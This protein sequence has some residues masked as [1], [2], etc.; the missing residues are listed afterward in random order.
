MRLKFLLVTWLLTTS[1]AVAQGTPAP[2]LFFSDLI[3]GANTG[4]SDKTYS[5]TGGVYVTL[6]GNYLDSYS[7]ITLNGSSCLTVV[8]A[9]AAYL[10]Y[11]KMVVKIGSG[12]NTGNFSITTP[13][14][15]WSGPM[16]ST[17]KEQRAADFTVSSGHIYYVSSSGKDSGTGS[18]S[19][20]W[21]SLPHAKLQMHAG[22]VTYAEN[23]YTDSSPDPDIGWGVITLYKKVCAGSQTLQ[24]VMA[25]YPGATVTL[26]ST[27]GV[28]AVAMYAS[29]SGPACW[30]YTFAGIHFLGHGTALSLGSS[31]TASVDNIRIIGNDI[32]CPNANAAA[33]CE[34]D[35][36]TSPTYEGVGLIMEGNNFHDIG[37]IPPNNNNLQHAIYH[38]GTI[39]IIDAWNKIYNVNGACRGIQI[40]SSNAR[41]VFYDIH[42]HDNIIHD[43][44]CDGIGYYGGDSTSTAGELY[45]GGSEIYNNVIYRTGTTGTGRADSAGIYISFASP[46]STSSIT[47]VYNNTIYDNRITGG[48]TC[49][50][51]EY[52]PEVD[53]QNNIIYQLVSSAPYLNGEGCNNGSD[54]YFLGANNLLYGIGNSYTCAGCTGT[55]TG[56]KPN[57]MNISESGCPDGCV[58][59]LSLA[60]SSSPANGAGSTRSPVPTY[61]I[62]GLI[63]RSPPSIGAYE[64]AAG[65]K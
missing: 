49:G 53:V 45:G 55:I 8:S 28:T 11:E 24:I 57:L 14:G 4:N 52:G 37:T 44:G 27:T 64:Y 19:S 38:G 5:A 34:S 20:P 36:S 7:A 61:D 12:C 60:S 50:G 41:M 51:Y 2:I 15:T 10:W 31:G 63:R 18:F 29:A 43:T 62:T 65:A 54:H 6:Y 56:H 23:G 26:G 40:F 17:A 21:A 16:P 9:P 47:R 30:G 25:A 42:V 59:N 3:L 1:M 13:G 35:G 58:T 33:G 32:S 22:D 46:V 48:V 39:S